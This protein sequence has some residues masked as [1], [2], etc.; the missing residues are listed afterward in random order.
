MLSILLDKAAYI[1]MSFASSLSPW[2]EHDRFLEDE[3]KTKDS[4]FVV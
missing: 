4:P 3:G 1:D 2:L